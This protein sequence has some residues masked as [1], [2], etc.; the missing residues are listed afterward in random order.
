MPTRAR[1]SDGPIAGVVAEHADLAGVARAVAL[2]HLDARRL[3]RAVGPQQTEDLAARD[4]EVDPAKRVLGAVRLA[5]P[6]DLDRADAARHRPHHGNIAGARMLCGCIDIGTNTTRVLVAEAHDGVLTEVLQRRAFTRLGRGLTAGGTIPA[7]RIAETAA[8]RRRAGRARARKRAPR[9]SA[10]SPPRSSA[11]PPTATSSA[12]RCSAHGGV[13]VCVLDGEEEARLAFLGATRTLGRPLDGPDRGRRRRRRLE[14]DRHRHAR[15]RRRVVEVVQRRLRVPGRRPLRER[16]ADARRARRRQRAGRAAC[17]SGS[18]RRRSTRRSRSAAAPRR[19]GG[20]SG[21]TL[22][23]VQPPARARL[24]HQR[25]GGGRRV[26]VRSRRP[27]GAAD[28]GRAARARRRRRGRWAGRCRSGAAVCARASCSTSPAC[29]NSF[30]A[31]V[32]AIICGAVTDV[33]SVPETAVAP[34]LTDPGL[35]FN[36]ELSWLQFNE[37]V[38]Q[39]AEDPSIP[40]LERVKFCAI[41]SSNLDEFFMVRVAGLHDQIDAGIEKPLQDGRSPTETI[42]AIRERRPQARGTPVALPGPRPAPRAG[43]ARDPDRRLRRGRRAR[44]ARARRALPAPDLPGAD[45]AGGRARPA[46]PVHLEPVAVARRAWS[47][48]RS[49]R[50]R[51]S[52]A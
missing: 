50:S 22:D 25:S 15:R 10:R 38:L 46:V 51:R 48:T 52:R 44:A 27:A 31:S 18:R 7:T 8:R 20:W 2:E 1:R 39:L 45:A 29:N 19:C 35:Y 12:P 47:A 30:T 4:R 24:A 42:D 36:R 16:P 5:Q 37:R 40:L 34:D 43:R 3:A 49:P 6:G 28:A 13:D 21:D 17:W 14:R 9:R 11:A 23:P 32:G 33:T 41:Y 26:P